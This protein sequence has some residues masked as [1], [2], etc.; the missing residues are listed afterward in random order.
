MAR[1]ERIVLVP[2]VELPLSFFDTSQTPT[3]LVMEDGTVLYGNPVTASIVAPHPPP[4]EMVGRRITELEPVTFWQERVALMQRL[5]REERDAVVNDILSG[6]QVAT[7]LRL[8]PAQPTPY[9][10][11]GRLFLIMLHPGGPITWARQAETAP[12]FYEPEH[13][14]LGPLALLSP[15]EL[16]V[17]ALVGEGL[18]A[19]QIAERLSRAVD[20]V[21]THRAALLRKLNCQNAVQLGRIA[22]RAG[23]RCRQ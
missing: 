12:V 20:T 6:R 9:P 8:L 3:N 10:E 16:E 13:Q 5:V 4:W 22:V 18:T 15:R 19:A 17:L 2:G 23:L 21:N 11:R 7:H 1:I 14:D